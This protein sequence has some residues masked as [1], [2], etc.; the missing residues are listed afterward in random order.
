MGCGDNRDLVALVIAPGIDYH[1]YRRGTDGFW[2]HK[3]GPTPATNLDNS[4]HT[5]TNPET[6]DRGMYTVFAGYFCA[7]SS[8]TEGQGHSVI[9]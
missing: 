8:S 4:G 3:M 5:I 9:N 6:A 1:W 2:T 7:C